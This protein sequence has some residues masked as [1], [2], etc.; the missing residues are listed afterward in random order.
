MFRRS[1]ADMS[2]IAF[3]LRK[4]LKN[5]ILELL[6]HPGKLVAYLFVAACL[7][8]SALSMALSPQEELPEFLDLRIL[9]GIYFALLMFIVMINL[10]KGV[11][12]G[13]TFFSMGEV[14]MLY[15][16][17]ISPNKNFVNGLMKQMG[18][19]VLVAS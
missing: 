13:S 10:I 19:T 4:S 17:P 1:V 16:S 8:F 3:I 18:M 2:S 15:I 9:Q 5:N 11:D 7:L 6:R 12:S 14:N